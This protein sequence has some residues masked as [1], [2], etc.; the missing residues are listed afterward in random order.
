MPRG[1][2]KIKNPIDNLNNDSMKETNMISENLEQLT[3]QASETKVTPETKKEIFAKYPSRSLEEL[4]KIDFVNQWESKLPKIEIPG[5]IVAWM[6]NSP[7]NNF[8]DQAYKQGYDYLDVTQ[9]PPVSSGYSD[10]TGEDRYAHYAMAIP[11]EIYDRN[12]QALQDIHKRMYG[13]ILNPDSKREE[14]QGDGMY[15]PGKRSVQT[16]AKVLE[17]P[18]T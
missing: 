18:Q 11:K 9:Y 5:F 3:K 7:N 14:R 13:D 1:I 12:Q 10:S 4:R 2:K 6:C 16:V 15:N 8:R 17:N